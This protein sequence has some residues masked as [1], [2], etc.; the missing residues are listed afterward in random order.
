MHHPFRLDTGETRPVQLSREKTSMNSG[1]KSWPEPNLGV[2][3]TRPEGKYYE[4]PLTSGLS[5]IM[6]NKKGFTISALWY[7]F[8]LYLVTALI[9]N[10]LYR[11]HVVT[12]RISLSP[13]VWEW[14]A[15]NGKMNN[16]HNSLF[17][18]QFHSINVRF[19]C[20]NI[21]CSGVFRGFTPQ[22]RE[23]G[24]ARVCV[25]RFKGI[26]KTDYCRSNACA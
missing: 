25:Y 8:M 18:F 21:T 11:E 10:H 7:P 9:R 6:G 16:P 4:D 14:G 3:W 1:L 26:R 13:C 15:V 19:S 22:S 2:N 23:I 5:W 17:S 20:W 12:G 24:R